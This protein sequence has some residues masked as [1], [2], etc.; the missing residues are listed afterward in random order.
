MTDR[1]DRSRRLSTHG[2]AAP[3]NQNRKATPKK[4]TNWHHVPGLRN[5]V[6][7]IICDHGGVAHIPSRCDPVFPLFSPRP[8]KVSGSLSVSWSNIIPSLSKCN[9]RP[10]DR[11]ER[12][13]H[14]VH[15]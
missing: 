5:V 14:L 7:A 15:S 12:D 6:S 10:F 13:D 8:Y 9:K 2:Q 4:V 1:V 11:T 3:K